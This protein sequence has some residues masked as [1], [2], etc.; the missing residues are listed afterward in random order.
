MIEQ[1]TEN[2][3][4]SYYRFKGMGPVADRDFILLDCIKREEDGCK[5]TFASA[6]IEYK[7]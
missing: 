3:S 6:S 4:I 1:L 2:I 7:M 5:I